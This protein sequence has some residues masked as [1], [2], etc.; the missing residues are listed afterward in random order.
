MDPPPPLKL[1]HC[2]KSLLFRCVVCCR[3]QGKMILNPLPP[4]L[5]KDSVKWKVP[6]MTVGV[7]HTGYFWYRD[8]YGKRK[9]VYI[10]LFVCATTRAV[11]LEPVTE[12]SI[13]S[14]L[15]CLRRLAA[16][17]G[18]P[19]TIHFD[20][21]WT[22]ISGKQFLLELQDDPQVQEYLANR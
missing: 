10:C 3:I 13:P 4:P 5:P 11:H 6:F 12:L 17:K 19:S 16:A 8:K 9:K 15:L 14:F 7:N 20:N 18:A 22:F 1:R 2:I 21:H